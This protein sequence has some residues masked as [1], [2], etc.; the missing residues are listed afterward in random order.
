M[1]R[2][3]QEVRQCIAALVESIMQRS[4]FFAGGA[5]TSLHC[6]ALISA[7]NAKIENDLV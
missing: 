7:D 6:H 2:K 1:I 4:S 3:N 5:G